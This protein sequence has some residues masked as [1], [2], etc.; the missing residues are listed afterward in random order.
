MREKEVLIREKLK[1]IT[2]PNC[3]G[4]LNYAYGTARCENDDWFAENGEL[5]E[6]LELDV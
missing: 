2:C 1:D 5:I 4:R 3:G 6:L